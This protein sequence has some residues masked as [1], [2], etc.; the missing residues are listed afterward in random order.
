MDGLCFSACPPDTLPLTSNPEYC[1][2]LTPC[3]AGTLEDATGTACV[4][5]AP[6]GITSLTS[7]SCPTGYTQWTPAEC[8]INCNAF[9]LENATE[10]KRKLIARRTA[11]P[12]CS[13]FLYSVQG[14]SCAL[15]V[16]ALLLLLLG[17][18]VC[19]FLFSIL[20]TRTS[21]PMRFYGGGH[22]RSSLP[23]RD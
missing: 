20:L 13:S 9:F 17:I 10:C 2:T 16:G 14:T 8:Y 23:S 21:T 1:V 15:N 3:Q 19:V 11:E 22:V 5:V 6:L 12:W 18:F 7:F 4:K